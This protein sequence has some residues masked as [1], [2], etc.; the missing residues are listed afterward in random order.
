MSSQ[1]WSFVPHFP[2]SLLKVL[3]L[4]EGSLSSCV[5]YGLQARKM[6]KAGLVCWLEKFQSTTFILKFPFPQIGLISNCYYYFLVCSTSTHKKSLYRNSL[7]QRH[8]LYLHK[9]VDVEITAYD[10]IKLFFLFSSSTGVI[11]PIYLVVENYNLVQRLSKFFIQLILKIN[12]HN[13]IRNEQS[14]Q[15]CHQPAVDILC[16]EEKYSTRRRTCTQM[17]QQLYYFE[18]TVHRGEVLILNIKAMPSFNIQAHYYPSLQNTSR[19]MFKQFGFPN[20]GTQLMIQILCS[21]N[22]ST[23][24]IVI[25]FEEY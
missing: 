15:H 12:V 5:I 9:S 3:I 11:N 4:S 21:S 20:W 1:S 18:N 10:V 16:K 23:Y 25:C 13:V 6:G 24:S 8:F 19:D 7:D 17:Q 22:I 2:P 14:W